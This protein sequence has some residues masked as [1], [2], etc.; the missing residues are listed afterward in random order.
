MN[1]ETNLKHS[2]IGIA[3]FVISLAAGCLL[4]ALLVIAGF[5]N[6]GRVEHGKPYPGQ[7]IV[8]LA[9]IALMGADVVAAG[10]GVASLFQNTKKRLFGILGLVFSS[11][12][13]LGGVGLVLIGIAYVNKMK[14]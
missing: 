5:L 11:L 7:T 9:L 4:L 13:L 8:G 12:T 10:L 14:G 3:S 1:D 2:G 6:S